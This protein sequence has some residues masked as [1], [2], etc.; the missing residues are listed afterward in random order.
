MKAG[1]AG[2]DQLRHDL[3]ALRSGN[4][5]RDRRRRAHPGVQKSTAGV[6]RAG[7]DWPEV[8]VTP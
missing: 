5:C 7:D 2:D 1:S 4:R 3:D 8:E 6:W